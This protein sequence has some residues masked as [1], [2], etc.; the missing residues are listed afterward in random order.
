MT[1]NPPKHGY[2][3]NATYVASLN[4]NM[5]DFEHLAACTLD[6][7]EAVV[8]NTMI[9]ELEE[10]FDE[11]MFTKSIMPYIDSINF[12]E[13]CYEWYCHWDEG[14]YTRMSKWDDFEDHLYDDMG[15]SIFDKI[16]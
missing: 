7:T 1:R 2:S 10:I 13:I 3:N 5:D 11:Q 6:K 14:Q 8:R 12:Y 4:L 16:A 15:V 9:A